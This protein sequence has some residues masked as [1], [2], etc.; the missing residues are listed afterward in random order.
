M[1]QSSKREPGHRKQSEGPY[2]SG[3]SCASLRSRHSDSCPS[4]PV[5]RFASSGKGRAGIHADSHAHCKPE[6]SARQ[7]GTA[8]PGRLRSSSVASFGTLSV[9]LRGGQ[10]QLSLKLEACVRQPT[11]RQSFRVL[12]TPLT[13][14]PVGK[15]PPY[16]CLSD[17]P[18]S[19]S[20]GLWR[21]SNITRDYAPLSVCTLPRASVGAACQRSATP[22][23]QRYV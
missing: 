6:Q 3:R 9:L 14:I 7:A 21:P 18:P 12:L 2:P 19:P 23:N 8:I 11:E 5:T 10:L 17:H 13:Y 16:C 22:H 1:M 15:K 4:P 20:R